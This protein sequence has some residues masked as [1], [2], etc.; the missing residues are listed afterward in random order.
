[1]KHQ[2]TISAIKALPNYFSDKHVI[3]LFES[4]DLWESA[5][6]YLRLP[7]GYAETD[8]MTREEA[9]HHINEWFRHARIAKYQDPSSYRSIMKRVVVR[10]QEN[11]KDHR[12]CKDIGRQI[13]RLH[14]LVNRES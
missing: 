14:Y 7:R 10:I 13:A 5:D 8:N 2:K 4:T 6:D 9:E 1:M 3:A 11:W 12:M